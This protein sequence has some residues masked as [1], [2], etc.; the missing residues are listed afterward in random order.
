MRMVLSVV[1]LNSHH[2]T[3]WGFTLETTVSSSLSVITASPQ[4][5]DTIKSPTPLL[6][7]SQNVSCFQLPGPLKTGLDNVYSVIMTIVV[8]T[9][10]NSE[11]DTID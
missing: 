2:W 11:T 9:Y 1:L 5:H 6:P 3:H 8:V 7:P 10:V 4:E